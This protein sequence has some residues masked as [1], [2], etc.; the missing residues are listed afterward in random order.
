MDASDSAGNSAARSLSP[1]GQQQQSANLADILE[2]VLDKGIV[3]VGDIRINLLDIEL[4]TIRLRLL[5][6]SVDKAREIGI[7]WW[8]HDP[9]LSSR[10]GK[11]RELEAENERLRAEVK[12]LRARPASRSE[13]PEGTRSRRRRTPEGAAEADEP[14][15]AP[16]R[17]SRRRE[18]EGRKARSRRDS[19][20]RAEDEDETE[21][22]DETEDEERRD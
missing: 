16:E 12:A 8:E 22:E 4:L 13:L 2:R 5:V 9:A 17:R 6:A 7:D 11:D 10:A 1:Y 21:A 20:T 3:I 18:P 14:R 15:A 19:D